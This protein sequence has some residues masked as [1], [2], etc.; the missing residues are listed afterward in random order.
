[1]SITRGACILVTLAVL[2][3]GDRVRAAGATTENNLPIRNAMEVSVEYLAPLEASRDIDTLNVNTLYQIKTFKR[4]GLSLFAGGT[5]TFAKGDITQQEGELSEGTLHEATY[6]TDAV[7]IGPVVLA[8][9]RLWRL[10]GLSALVEASAGII[11]YNRDFPAGGD[12]YNFMWRV[13][14][15]LQYAIGSGF[16]V[17]IGWLWMHVSNGQGTG[18]QN[19]S[20]DASGLS[21]QFSFPF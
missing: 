14:P 4:I 13:G 1:M 2:L 10:N 12:R 15:V 21:F 9:L 11:V 5:A 19:P 17:G 6:D 3:S 7:G 20:Y 16:L 18:P 8:D